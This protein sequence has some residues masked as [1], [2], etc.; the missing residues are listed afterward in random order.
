ME[1]QK[2]TRMVEMRSVALGLVATLAVVGPVAWTDPALAQ[3]TAPA[4]SQQGAQGD[5]MVEGK[6]AKVSGAKLTL[7]DGT[8]LMIP[9]DVKVQ[10]ADLK[11]GAT[12]KASFEEH[13]GQKVVTAI[14]VE[15]TK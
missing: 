10:R 1:G 9:S 6:I 2:M 7:A 8:V 4:A 3:G 12:V 5:Q 11:P 14:A 13:G 15:P